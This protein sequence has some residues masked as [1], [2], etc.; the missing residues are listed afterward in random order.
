MEQLA[1]QI[2]EFSSSIPDI[3]LFIRK[4]R[5]G[6]EHELVRGF[7]STAVESFKSR[8]TNLAVFHEPQLDTGF[9]DLVFVEYNPRIF[10]RWSGAR[11][12]LSLQDLKLLHHLSCIRGADSDI[13]ERQL[14]MNSKSLLLS[15]ERLLDSKLIRRYSRQWQTVSLRRT[16]GISRIT[17]FEAKIKDWQSAFRQAELNKWFA[18][19]SNIVSPV[20]KPSDKIISSSAKLG[21]GIYTYNFAG[22]N[23]ITPAEAN[24]IPSCYVSWLFNEW[25]G[26]SLW[27][28]D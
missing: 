16:F 13:L 6:P 22:L 1:N 25:I 3:G 11:S 17:S 2:V 10:D 4:R 24:S 9:P 14:G 21:V 18:S 15:L 8:S 5:N 7:T 20:A 23:L 19:E 28:R 27:S 26:R 12:N